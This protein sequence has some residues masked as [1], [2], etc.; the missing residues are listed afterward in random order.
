MAPTQIQTQTQTYDGSYLDPNVFGGLVDP[1]AQD[2][3]FNHQQFDLRAGGTAERTQAQGQGI[4]GVGDDDEMVEDKYDE[5][6]EDEDYDEESGSEDF[7]A[8][9]EQGIEGDGNGNQGYEGDYDED[10]GADEEDSEFDE[11]ME[12]S[13]DDGEF[14]ELMEPEE[15]VEQIVDADAE[16]QDAPTR[17]SEPQI[18]Q[19]TSNSS[20]PAAPGFGLNTSG[21]ILPQAGQAG[22]SFQ[23]SQPYVQPFYPG[24]GFIPLQAGQS[25]HV[26]VPQSSQPVAPVYGSNSGLYHHSHQSGQP[27]P[28]STDGF[29]QSQPGPSRHYGD[30]RIR[31]VDESS[32][33]HAQTRQKKRKAQEDNQ[34]SQKRV[35]FIP[36]MFQEQAV[37]AQRELTQAQYS[38]QELENARRLGTNSLQK[39]IAERQ[40]LTRRVAELNATIARMQTRN[41]VDATIADLEGMESAQQLGESMDLDDDTLVQAKRMRAGNILQQ[42]KHMHHH[43]ASRAHGFWRPVSNGGTPGMVSLGPLMSRYFS[44]KNPTKTNKTLL[45]V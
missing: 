10:M 4:E 14:D 19:H 35:P 6:Y 9:E 1:W 25:G 36:Q 37:A 22:L 17:R 39:E 34:H 18:Q 27:V 38:I 2:I 43:E 28:S 30:P 15:N 16:M 29:V 11:E 5:E 33:Q 32:T 45:I 26:H 12:L 42:K 13:H 44:G 31:P 3:E 21:F 7:E 41:M 23:S 8:E 24:Y 40:M 20:Q